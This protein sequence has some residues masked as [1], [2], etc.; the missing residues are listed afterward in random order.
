MVSDAYRR[1]T[2]RV[3]RQALKAK[4]LGVQAALLAVA[5]ELNQVALEARK[6]SGVESVKTFGERLPYSSSMDS[7]LSM[8][9]VLVTSIFG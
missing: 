9:T 8:L 1:R 7:A 2:D 4:D 3:L 6:E 5:I